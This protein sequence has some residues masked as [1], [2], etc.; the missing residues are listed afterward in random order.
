MFANPLEHSA[1]LGAMLC[2]PRLRPSAI[3][4]GVPSVVEGRRGGR[5]DGDKS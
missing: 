2:L 3:A 4:Q 1:S 5:L